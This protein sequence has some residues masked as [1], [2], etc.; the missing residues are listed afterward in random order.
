MTI[1]SF[2]RHI[3]DTQA[4]A[5]YSTCIQYLKDCLDNELKKDP[6]AHQDIQYIISTCCSFINNPKL[7]PEYSIL[8]A[9]LDL[10]MAYD[11]Q[12]KETLSPYILS[13]YIKN[14]NHFIKLLKEYTSAIKEKFE[15][16]THE[17]RQTIILTLLSKVETL[18]LS[19]YEFSQLFD[20]LDKLISHIH[21]INNDI[22]IYKRYWKVRLMLHEQESPYGILKKHIEEI[23]KNIPLS[24]NAAEIIK[25][26]SSV[27][28]QD[29]H[30]LIG[31]LSSRIKNNIN[32]KLLQNS[33]S[34]LIRQELCSVFEIIVFLLKNVP[35]NFELHY[36]LGM[37]KKILECLKPIFG[38]SKNLIWSVV[39][40]DLLYSYI[41]GIVEVMLEI[42]Y[43]I[44]LKEELFRIGIDSL[45]RIENVTTIKKFVDEIQ[46]VDLKKYFLSILRG[47]KDKSK[48]TS[49]IQDIEGLLANYSEAQYTS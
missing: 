39:I 9:C 38:S 41:R 6:I 22:E 32:D 19:D 24:H 42:F 44:Y 7:N 35:K 48:N 16:Y 13:D 8:S 30:N 33:N 26:F 40:N 3:Q 28:A 46:D 47:A 10:I 45:W 18:Q 21:I 4:I 29:S 23:D 36:Y 25:K 34:I 37:Q 5:Y 1:N 12:T 20:E 14:T 2:V 49:L 11:F 31:D 43:N 17:G 27:Y 15:E